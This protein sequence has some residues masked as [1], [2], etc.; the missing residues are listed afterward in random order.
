MIKTLRTKE[1]IGKDG[2]KYNVLTL[3]GSGRGWEKECYYAFEQLTE[4]KVEVTKDY[5]K[6]Y[7]EVLVVDFCGNENAIYRD[8]KKKPYVKKDGSFEVVG[9]YS[10]IFAKA[11]EPLIKDGVKICGR[12]H[13]YPYGM[14]STRKIVY[15]AD[16]GLDIS[17]DDD[18]LP[19]TIV[20]VSD[21]YD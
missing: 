10:K 18:S 4:V 15:K 1:M 8:F 19:A 6:G 16:G 5:K 20:K 7:V 2:L 17:V 21:L 11:T 12:T 3:L 14:W 9:S 13:Y